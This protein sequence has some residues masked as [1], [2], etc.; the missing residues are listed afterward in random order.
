M[1]PHWIAEYT[2]ADDNEPRGIS[3][4]VTGWF[5][6]FAAA[7]LGRFTGEPPQGSFTVELFHKL[8]VS[9]VGKNVAR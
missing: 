4:A 7:R 2:V 9:D 6:K 5:A 3:A 1:S 8:E